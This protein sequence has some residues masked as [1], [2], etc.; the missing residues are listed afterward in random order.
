VEEKIF[1][2][3][4]I[5]TKPF[6]LSSVEIIIPFHNEQ[7]KV[8]NLIND[9]F[10]TVQKNKY[11]IT[12]VDDGS[13]NK[14]FVEQLQKKK[15]E[16]LRFL[17]ND[18]CKGFGASVNN[19]LKNPFREDIPFVAILHSDVRLQDQ[20]W[21]FN[22]GQSLYVM[23]E[24]DV[25]MVSSMTDNPTVDFA[26]LKAKKGEMREDSILTD[27]FLPM[28][29]VLANRELFK[30]VGFLHE[31]PYAGVETE[32]F[33]IRMAKNGYKQGVCGKSWVHHEGSGT[34]RQLNKN[35]KAQ[36]ILRN[37]RNQFDEVYKNN[38]QI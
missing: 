3:K 17:R 14:S 16:G 25:K 1:L 13:I 12:L 24:N 7:A 26:S 19:A 29:C 18:K 32:E 11:V 30:R 34:L 4:N 5:E 33:A 21:L 38:K 8:I 9:I 2:N 28:Y 37:V 31:C 10:N 15:V 6:H 35:K 27:G 22:L 23:K 20:N 36:E